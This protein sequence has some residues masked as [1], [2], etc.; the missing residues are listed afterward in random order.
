MFV[1][2][3]RAHIRVLYDKFKKQLQYRKS[4]SQSLLFPAVVQLD[5]EQEIAFS[6]ISEDLS[7]LGFKFN[8]LSGGEVEVLSVPVDLQGKDSMPVLL[9]MIDSINNSGADNKSLLT[10]KIA[11]KMAKSLAVREG[12]L[13]SSDEMDALISDLSEC[14]DKKYTP[15][16]NI[17]SYLLTD[18][19]LNNRF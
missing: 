11:L 12:Q 14:Q 10:D 18:L 4:L 6:I 5:K 17:I 1:H 19:E 15:D 9:E 7:A 3:Q 8:L 16:G 13:L 2:Q